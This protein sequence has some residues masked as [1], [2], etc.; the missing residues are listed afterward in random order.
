MDQLPGRRDRGIAFLTNLL[1]LNAAVE[2]AR[3]GEQGRGFAVVASEVRSLAQRTSNA[4][5][6][7]TQLI[8]ESSSRIAAGNDQTECASNAMND[9][10][11]MVGKVNDGIGN[12]SEAA[13]EQQVGIEEINKALVHIDLLNQENATMVEQTAANCSALHEMATGVLDAMKV[14]SL[15]EA[16]GEVH[17]DKTENTAEAVAS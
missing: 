2:A 14:F 15:G 5:Q 12:I 7:I 1:A 4:A 13:R 6:Q 16:P 11:Q 3:A 8:V 10:L 9:A 17:Q